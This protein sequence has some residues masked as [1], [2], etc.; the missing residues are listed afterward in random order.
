MKAVLMLGVASV[1]MAVVYIVV[2]PNYEA[3][4]RAASRE[5]SNR[6]GVASGASASSM[7]FQPLSP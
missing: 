4:K 3:A 5:R 1:T 7:S 2:A 6:A